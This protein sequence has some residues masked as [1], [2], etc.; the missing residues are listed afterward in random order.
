MSRRRCIET[1]LM[2]P[3]LSSLKIIVAVITTCALLWFGVNVYIGKQAESRLLE[4]TAASE[5]SHSYRLR[6]LHHERG[7]LTSGGYVDV[8]LIDE[9]GTMSRPE[10]MKARVSYELK[11]FVFPLALM[12]INWSIEPLGEER[13]TF[14]R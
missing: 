1:K 11:H 8:V 13:E 10:W 4:L 3:S 9:C 7:F 5:K 14:E 2:K 6:N 12:N